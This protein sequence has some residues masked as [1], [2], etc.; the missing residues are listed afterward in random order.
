MNN[1]LITICITLFVG[2]ILAGAVLVPVLNDTTGA[3]KTYINEG[4]YYALADPDDDTSYVITVKSVD[5]V[6]VIDLDGEAITSTIT[7]GYTVVFGQHSII[8]YFPEN[9]RVILGGTVGAGTSSQ[10]TDLRSADSSETLTLTITGDT[11]VTVNGET[12]KTISDNWAFINPAGDYSYCYNPCVT[13]S[14]RII[15]GG[16]TYSPFSSATVICFDGTIEGID[17]GVYRSSPTVTLNDT[18]INTSNVATNLFRIDSIVFNCTQSDADKTATYTY[19]LAPKEVVYD[20]PNY[21]GSASA[22]IL[23]A[24]PIL[25]IVSLILAAVGVIYVNRN[26]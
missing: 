26:D 23:G 13:A 18:V 12:T 1:K 21:V 19:F 5:D 15:G 25:V 20:N 2:I 6:A 11:L 4:T 17:A 7:G 16:V 8:R 10:F 14:D 22:A 24:I 3:T 9:G